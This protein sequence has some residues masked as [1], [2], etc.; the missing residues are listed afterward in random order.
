MP[1]CLFAVEQL[2]HAV[3][4]VICCGELSLPLASESY[5]AQVDT[6]A[7]ICSSGPLASVAWGMVRVGLSGVPT[8]C[9]PFRGARAFC[10]P[11]A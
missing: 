4:S 10:S 7:E 1:T 11:Q 3:T 5:G 2:R 8:H 6:G 9:G